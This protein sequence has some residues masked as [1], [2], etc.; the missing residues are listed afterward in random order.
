MALGVARLGRGGAEAARFQIL[1]LLDLAF[2]E[3]I[4][5]ATHRP[6]VDLSACWR[7]R[8]PERGGRRRASVSRSVSAPARAEQSH[9]QRRVVEG[10]PDLLGQDRRSGVGDEITVRAVD[11]VEDQLTS[12]EVLP[13]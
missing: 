11:R 9:L 12:D 13:L 8:L 2:S 4:R 1:F 6:P 5:G 3:L 10:G 7:Q